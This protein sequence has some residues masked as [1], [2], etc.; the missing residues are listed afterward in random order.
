MKYFKNEFK[1][2]SSLPK[3]ENRFLEI[4]SILTN[5]SQRI[6]LT[7]NASEN[8]CEDDVAEVAE[9]VY[10]A[11]SRQAENQSD[12]SQVWVENGFN[13]NVKFDH[14]F[15][16]QVHKR[17]SYFKQMIDSLSKVWNISE[18]LLVISHSAYDEE[19]N[20]IVKSIKFCPVLQLFYPLR[21]ELFREKF[22]DADPEHC[23]GTCC[24]PESKRRSIKVAQIAQIKHH[25]WWKVRNY[26]TAALVQ[27]FEYIEELKKSDFW[28]TLL[29]E[30]HYASPDLY[31]TLKSVIKDKLKM[32]SLTF[33]S[34]QPFCTYNDY[35]WDWTLNHIQTRIA[36]N[37]KAVVLKSSRLFHIGDW[38]FGTHTKSDNCNAS[39][40]AVKNYIKEINIRTYTFKVDEGGRL[41]A[42]W[43][44][45]QPYGAWSIITCTY[46]TLRHMSLKII[47]SVCVVNFST[48]SAVFNMINMV[49]NVCVLAKSDKQRRIVYLVG[50]VMFCRS[51]NRG[52]SRGFS[53]ATRAMSDEEEEDSAE[54]NGGVAFARQ[55]G[56]SIGAA[57]GEIGDSFSKIGTP[58]SCLVASIVP[59]KRLLRSGDDDVDPA[60]SR[61]L[62]L[63][64]YDQFGFKIGKKENGEENG[65]TVDGNQ[66]S[67]LVEEECKL[68][69]RWIAYLEFTFDLGKGRVVFAQVGRVGESGARRRAPLVATVRL[70][71]AVRRDTTAPAGRLHL[72]RHVERVEESRRPRRQRRLFAHVRPD[73]E[74]SDAHVAEQRLLRLAGRRGRWTV[75]S[76]FALH[77]VGVSRRRLLSGNGRDRGHSAS[78]FGRRER[79]LDDVHDI[80]RPAAR[81]V[82]FR[83]VA[84][85]GGR[86]ADISPTDRRL[87]ARR[88]RRVPYPRHRTV[89][90]HSPLVFDFV[91]VVGDAVPN[92][93]ARLG[94]VLLLRFDGA[95]QSGSGDAQTAPR[96]ISGVGQL[97][98]RVQFVVE[99]AVVV[100]TDRRRTVASCDRP[101]RHRR[102]ALAV[103]A[104]HP[105][106]L[107]ATGPSSSDQ[108]LRRRPSTVPASPWTLSCSVYVVVRFRPIVVGEK[109][110]T[111]RTIGRIEA[112]DR[113]TGT[114]NGLSAD[115][116]VESHSRDYDLYTEA[117]RL[118]RRWAR[119]LVDFE[120][121][122]DDELGF[123]KN[124]L[125][126]V[127]SR[128]DEHCWIGELN[129]RR[130]WF[131][132]KFVQ[133]VDDQ[134]RDYSTFPSVVETEDDDD[135]DDDD[136]DFTEKITK[137]VRHQ[138]CTILKT[139]FEY[140]MKKSSLL[141]RPF[142]PWLFIESVANEEIRKEHLSVHSRL[143]LSQ[144][145]QLDQD[146]QTFTPEE[147]LYKALQYSLFDGRQIPIV[148]LPRLERTGVALV[149][150]T[151]LHQ[152]R[153]SGRPVVPAV[154]VHPQSRLGAVEMR[155]QAVGAVCI[156]AQLGLGIA[157][158]QKTTG[159]QP[160]PDSR[161]RP[162]HAAQAPLVQ[163]GYLI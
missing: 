24:R 48:F 61:Y 10:W 130:G 9:A 72:R 47:L 141:G 79:V 43:V 132:A 85:L 103:V 135:D 23:N 123:C 15:M 113:R 3:F 147:L 129:G 108:P 133:L 120:R 22:P 46:F 146:G 32:R 93:V 60:S 7:K 59:S 17:P 142:H 155:T 101:T 157:D 159:E 87:A 115:Y 125:V 152:Q 53:Q 57:S 74:R 13:H 26:P 14:V 94:F 102:P 124:D 134:L 116:S 104:R 161:K 29:E 163:L 56:L 138:F 45:P 81:P 140:G 58:C 90:G 73:R 84:R 38:Y 95:V 11:E 21:M 76:D 33:Y 150:R 16:I 20:N 51:Q 105:T 30:D 131:P 19:M 88:R 68:R 145:F 160:P 71:A 1:S 50:T 83:L 75:A 143:M 66:T 5:I 62:C 42:N 64:D 86:P 69:L 27:A 67:L 153:R 2:S 25:W 49:S 151:A 127:L 34:D 63:D 109:C 37:W 148:G 126:E 89:S 162:R 35:N 6:N 137:L 122:E 65:R 55:E 91:R 156:Q 97:G 114:R 40:E 12:H 128:R 121:H 149:V 139:I 99:H 144:T 136:N 80:G 70:A 44:T 119:A 106:R 54:C 92:T 110:S 52:Y 117:H 107:L 158:D 118:T 31:E 8:Y 98:R 4:Y 28:I 82:L 112:D 96:P 39:L 41:F 100:G 18:V 77:C 78:I 36:R 154:V 111:N